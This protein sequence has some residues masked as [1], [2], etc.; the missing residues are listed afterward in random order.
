MRFTFIFF[1][2][3]GLQCWAGTTGFSYYIDRASNNKLDMNAR[4]RALIKAGDLTNVGVTPKQINQIKFFSSDKDWYM[5]NASLIALAKI[6]SVEA[7]VEAKKLLNDKSLVVRSAA[8][9]I[10]AKSLTA[11]HKKIL[12]EEFNKPYN[13]HKKSSLWIRK[14]IIEKLIVF[15][16][17]K[18]RHFFVNSLFDSDVEIAQLSAKALEKITGQQVGDIKSIEKWQSIVKKNNWL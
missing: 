11:E 16:D 10:L 1:W 7:S 8:V 17:I 14:Q 2:M 3:Y 15:A 12:A 4:W 18:D 9:D 5:R 6:N 13:F